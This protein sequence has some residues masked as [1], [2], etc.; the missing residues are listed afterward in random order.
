MAPYAA[1]RA[2]LGIGVAHASHLRLPLK[3][4]VPHPTFMHCHF[5][6]SVEGTSLGPGALNLVGGCGPDGGEGPRSGVGSDDGL[7]RRGC[8][9]DGGVGLII[10]AGGL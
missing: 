4:H 8:G 10:G 5:P 2:R 9:P 3:F 7:D 1:R 6:P